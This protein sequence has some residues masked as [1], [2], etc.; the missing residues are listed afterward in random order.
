MIGSMTDAESRMSAVVHAAELGAL[1]DDLVIAVHRAAAHRYGDEHRQRF[2][3]LSLRSPGH[4]IDLAEFLLAGSCT[5][6]IVRQRFR[7]DIESATVAFEQ[8][9]SGG[10]VDEI[11]APDRGDVAHPHLATHRLLTVSSEALGEP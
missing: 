1:V 5:P 9:Q 6:G 4:V 8:L 11:D 2:A 3:A 10:L 7:Y